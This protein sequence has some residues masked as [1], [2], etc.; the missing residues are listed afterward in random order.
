[1]QLGVAE[2]LTHYPEANLVILGAGFDTRYY[3][4]AQLLP[5]WRGNCVEVDFPKL[6]RRKVA[7]KLSNAKGCTQSW[8]RQGWGL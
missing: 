7:R 5:E 4:L 8:N 3:G 1:M 6:M 2:F